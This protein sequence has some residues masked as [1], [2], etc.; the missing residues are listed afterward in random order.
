SELFG[1]E[2]GAFTGAFDRRLGRFEVADGAT[3]FLDEIGELPLEL[4]AKLLR[5]IQDGEFERLGSSRTLKVDVR[6]IA[7]TN[8][9]LEEEVRNG[10][11][12][13]DLWYRL[14]IFPITVPPL[15]NRKQDLPLLVDFFVD[16]VSRKLGKSIDTIPKSAMNSLENY[17]WPGNVRELENV[18]ERAVINTSGNKL[19]LMDTL[20][21]P[22]KQLTTTPKTLETVERD[23]IILILEETRWKVAGKNGASEILGLNSSTLRARMRKL[24]IRKP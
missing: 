2:R 21:N 8:R 5:V 19:R 3:L 11:F 9:N 1:Y 10:R 23:H 14:N 20:D 16:R 13:K 6:I 22:Q 17:H 24:G 12:R 18:I 15:R 7:A 4:Q